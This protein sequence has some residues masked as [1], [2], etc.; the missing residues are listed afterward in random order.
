MKRMYRIVY[1]EKYYN[2][3]NI[4]VGKVFLSMT[5]SSGVIKRKIY[6]LTY[7]KLLCAQKQHKVTRQ[8][9]RNF[10]QYA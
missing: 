9:E 5:Q 7:R 4:E 1:M 6:Q 3:Y 8:K 2:K 10:L